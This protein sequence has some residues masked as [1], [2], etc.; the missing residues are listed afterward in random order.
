MALFYNEQSSDEVGKTL[1]A[2]VDAHRFHGVIVKVRHVKN[3]FLGEECA[4]IDGL[5]A[6]R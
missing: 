1:I 5:T 2:Q 6:E 4:G 3:V